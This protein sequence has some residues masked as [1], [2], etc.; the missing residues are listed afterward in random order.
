M[1]YAILAMVTGMITI[2]FATKSLRCILK[3][4]CYEIVSLHIEVVSLQSRQGTILKTYRKLC[5]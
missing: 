3:L 5:S 1:C 2:H 4:F